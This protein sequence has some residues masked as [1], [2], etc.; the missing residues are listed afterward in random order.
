MG[1]GGGAVNWLRGLCFVFKEVIDR[2]FEL[3]VAQI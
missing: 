3:L 1:K 2:L